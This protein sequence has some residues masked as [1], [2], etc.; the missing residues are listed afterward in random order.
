MK[1]LKVVGMGLAAMLALL[2]MQSVSA[3]DAQAVQPQ[4]AYTVK[5]T[6]LKALAAKLEANPALA[7]GQCVSLH[8]VEAT[9]GSLSY[10]CTKPSEKTDSAFRA[11]M[12]AG[13]SVESTTVG[14]AA[15]CVMT[16]CP[17]PYL[18]CCNIVTHIPCQ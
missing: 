2:A 11:A 7:E 1:H 8:A 3:A 15:G 9:T 12:E 13:G 6:D 18:R 5:A 16:Y 10:S 4:T 14:C 17:V